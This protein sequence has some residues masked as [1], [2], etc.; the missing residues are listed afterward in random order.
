MVCPL[1]REA[2]KAFPFGEGA[3]QREAEEVIKRFRATSSVLTAAKALSIHLPQRGRLYCICAKWTVGDACPYKDNRN[4]HG[5]KVGATTSPLA[6]LA[7]DL[8]LCGLSACG[9]SERLCRDVVVR[10]GAKSPKPSLRV[11]IKLRFP[12]R[13]SSS[14]ASLRAKSQATC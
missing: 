10:V 6:D 7:S 4:L 13:A 14:P 3:E 11:V 2:T 8:S 9:I 1:G 5:I 12:P